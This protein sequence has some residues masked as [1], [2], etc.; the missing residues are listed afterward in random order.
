MFKNKFFCD[1]KDSIKS[2]K[3]YPNTKY[4]LDQLLDVIVYVM[5]TGISWRSLDSPAKHARTNS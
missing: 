4:T 3:K 1:L 5:E 2:I